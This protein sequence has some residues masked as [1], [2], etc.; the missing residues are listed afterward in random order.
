MH[1]GQTGRLALAM[2]A[3]LGAGLYLARTLAPAPLYLPMP[4]PHD[5]AAQN[6][7]L[8]A[9]YQTGET[10]AQ[11][12]ATLG[13]W[14]PILRDPTAGAKDDA[15]DYS[16]ERV[17]YD[18]R[19]LVDEALAR[20]APQT[21]GK[22]DLYVVAFAGDGDENVFRNETE[23]VEKL[24]SQRYGA[25]DRIVVLQ[26][27]P[28]TVQQRPL[29][30]WSNLELVLDGLLRDNRFDPDEDILLLFMTSH[31]DEDHY[32]YVGMGDLPLDWI[33]ADDLSQTLNARPFRW[34]VNIVS[35]CYS[36]GF[37]DGLKNSTSMVITA[38]R[39]DRTS[40]G[41]G[42]DSDITYFG[43]AFLVEGLNQTD[44]FRGAFELARQLVEE[45]ED[46]DEQEH[47]EP[48]IASTPLIEAK[49]AD[50]RRG[51]VLGPAQAFEPAGKAGAP[52]SRTK[53]TKE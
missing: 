13:D 39:G 5:A 11:A 22:T 1:W 38:A 36:G 23:Y 41:C 51:I 27:S 48:Q 29:A 25:K 30:S 52:H 8:G 45:W 47:S 44:S 33:R 6:A 4:V 43:K 12:R 17:L 35:A 18:Q 24:F 32:F 15:P 46:R 14:F 42:S 16:A 2:L 31:G 28:Y 3:G 40:F 50:W 34:R 53:S 9:L 21:P 7:A 20:L 37:L 10:L 49:L 19:R 26:N